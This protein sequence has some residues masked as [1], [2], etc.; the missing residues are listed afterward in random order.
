MAPHMLEY[1]RTSDSLLLVLATEGNEASEKSCA[2][3]EIGGLVRPKGL[4]DDDDD[5]EG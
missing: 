2:D 1:E 4:R 3:S 5:D